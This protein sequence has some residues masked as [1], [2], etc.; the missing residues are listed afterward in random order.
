MRAFEGTYALYMMLDTWSPGN[1][2]QTAVLVEQ[3]K[4]I[5]RAAV[6]AGVEVV[7]HSGGPTTDP[8]KFPSAMCNGRLTWPGSWRS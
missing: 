7:L 6:A 3:G 5:V 1:V 8:L 4:R 2:G